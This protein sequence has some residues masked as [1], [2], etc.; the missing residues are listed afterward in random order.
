MRADLL[1]SRKTGALLKGILAI[2]VIVLTL[3]LLGWV[4]YHGRT[5]QSDLHE[6]LKFGRR[7]K[8]KVKEVRHWISEIR[9]DYMAK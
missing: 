6:I 2:V 3:K 4:G 8:V 7:Y 1:V 9:T 5:R